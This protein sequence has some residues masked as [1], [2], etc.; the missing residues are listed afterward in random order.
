MPSFENNQ[1]LVYKIYN[2][3]FKNYWWLKED[4]IQEGNIGLYNACLRFNKEYGVAFSTFASRCI[5]NEMYSYLI[6]EQKHINNCVS[7]ETMIENSNEELRLEEVI[8]DDKN[9]ITTFEL[10][11]FLDNAIKDEKKRTIFFNNLQGKTNYETAEEMGMS[12]AYVSKN[13]IKAKN[14]I[15][16]EVLKEMGMC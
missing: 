6:K 1:M 10:I 11:A 2:K 13:L 15:K 8:E 3:L 9:D 4:L 7:F 5:I 14:H 16:D 12:P